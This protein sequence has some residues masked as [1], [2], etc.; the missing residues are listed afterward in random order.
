[1]FS[2]KT[3]IETIKIQNFKTHKEIDLFALTYELE[4]VAI[5]ESIQG[6]MNNVIQYL[7]RPETDKVRVTEIILDLIDEEL[8]NFK[9]NQ[10]NYGDE[11]TFE[12]NFPRL[13]FSLRQD[14]FSI[15]DYK[16]VRQMPETVDLAGNKDEVFS[17]LDKHEFFVLREHLEQA[18]DNH[19]LGKWAAANAQLRAYTEGLFDTFADKIFGSTVAGKTSN[20]KRESL[21]RTNPPLLDPSLNE[22]GQEGK[23]FSNRLMKRLHP[24]GPHLGL[25]S[26]EDCTFRLQLVLLTSSYYLKK[27]DRG[28]S[29]N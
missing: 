19:S 13:F 3:V 28:I 14:G 6:R 12:G 20:V 9:K 16:V 5:G 23:N 8:Q 1:M 17:L 10:E 2:R 25:S 21:G 4:E 18:L 26:D 22:L 27:F 7:I 24:Q 15:V 29:R 11:E